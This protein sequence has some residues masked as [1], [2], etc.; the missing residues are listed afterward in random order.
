M[1]IYA[2]K[3]FPTGDRIVT[4]SLDTTVKIWEWNR[5]TPS[6]D[7]VTV[8]QAHSAFVLSLALDPTG[9]LIVSGSKDLSAIISSVSARAVLY[10][11]KGHLNSVIS[12]SYNPKGGMLCTGSGDQTVK[13]WAVRPAEVE[14]EES[15]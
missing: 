14:R 8:F 12:V 11:I 1:G 13:I 6:L 15:K 9:D 2:L 5:E 7:L 3:F 10:R 4:G